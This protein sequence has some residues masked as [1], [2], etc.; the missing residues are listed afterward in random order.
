MCVLCVCVR[1]CMM[2]VRVFAYVWYVC[3][4]AC[5]QCKT[6][7]AHLFTCQIFPIYVYTVHIM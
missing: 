5:V 3:M 6:K 1:V 7:F 2:Y 4:C